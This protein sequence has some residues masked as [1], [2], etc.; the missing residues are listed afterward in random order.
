M[1]PLLF[2]RVREVRKPNRAN[3][4]D[5][6]IDFYVPHLTDEDIRIIPQNENQMHQGNLRFKYDD[7]ENIHISLAPGGRVLIPSG[8][9]VLIDPR[10]SMLMAANKSGVATK[11]GLLYTAEIVDSTYTGEVHI[12][13]FNSSPQRV[14]ISL[15]LDEK[16]M[17]F[18][19][20]PV[21]LSTPVE[22][23]EE[24]YKAFEDTWGTRGAS[25]FG[26][27]DNK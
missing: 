13:V 18:V 20:V 12:G 14:D 1:K 23:T 11:R 8:V 4:G 19:H 26:S 10:E 22:V 16:L 27:S 7:N 17:Q 6:G 9:R 3:S 21:I 2:T 5:A 24:Q 15:T 25:G